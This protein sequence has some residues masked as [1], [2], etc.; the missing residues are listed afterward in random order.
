MGQLPSQS[1]WIL[2][3]KTHPHPCLVLGFTQCLCVLW[4]SSTTMVCL[5][6]RGKLVGILQSWQCCWLG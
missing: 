5:N 4:A 1:L 2:K 6:I 3:F